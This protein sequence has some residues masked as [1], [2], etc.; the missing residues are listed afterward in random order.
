MHGTNIVSQIFVAM[1]SSSRSTDKPQEQNDTSIE[2]ISSS[3]MAENERASSN[4]LSSIFS[5]VKDQ[6]IDIVDEQRME[7]LKHCRAIENV[8][9]ECRRFNKLIKQQQQ[10]STS[11]ETATTTAS[12]VKRTMHLEDIPP[13]I[14]ILKY[15]DWRNVHDFDHKCSREKHAVWACRAGA[16][17]CGADLVK[18]RNCFN[19]AVIP[20][21]GVTDL[22]NKNFGAVLNVATTAYEPSKLKQSNDN[23]FAI[24]C[25]EFQEKMGLCIATNATALAERE[26]LRSE[27]TSTPS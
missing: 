23:V 11:S 5:S 10:Q 19:A 14:R 21:A 9:N 17:Q 13:G 8:Y 25:R 2:G 1:T 12:T 3:T 16:L 27:K 22:S 18:L 24:P 20:P 6:L 26:M 4:P 7:R 15:Y